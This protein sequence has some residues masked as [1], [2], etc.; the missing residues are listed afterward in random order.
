MNSLLGVGAEGGAGEVA[1]RLGALVAV[2]VFLRRELREI[3]VG[4]FARGSA[5]AG[6]SRLEA[7]AKGRPDSRMAGYIIVGTLPIAILGLA[8]RGCTEARISNPIIIAA[9]IFV[10]GEILWLT[11]RPGLLRPERG[12]DLRASFWIG[13]AQAAALLPGMSRCGVTISTGLLLDVNGERAARFG[14]LLSVPVILGA[15]VLEAKGISAWPAKEMRPLLI[16]EFL[17][18]AVAAFLA[19]HLLTSIIR[20]ERLY[21]I[22][23]YCW[24][25]AWASATYFWTI[26]PPR[27]W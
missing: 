24:A 17:S 18:A 8:L 5:R 27:Y 12:I 14:F 3:L 26:A 16:A 19:L 11:R 7:A 4:L 20:R 25:I 9:L 10:T 2:L 6:D 22:A 1:A 13:L 15:A 23:Y 21:G